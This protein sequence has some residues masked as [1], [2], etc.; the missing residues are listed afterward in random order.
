MTRSL[1]LLIAAGASLAACNSNTAPGNDREAER[2]APAQ[3]APRMNASEA[4]SGIATAA[5]QPETMT[6]ADVASVA[7]PA[8]GCVFSM[9]E[10]GFPSFLYGEGDDPGIVK[11]NGKLIILPSGG[12]GLYRDGGL[13]V[14]MRPVD[15]ELGRG[16][17]REAEMIIMLPSAEDELGFRGFSVC[18]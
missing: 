7:G 3:A 8:G 12:D 11:L 18:R 1:A 9:T 2:E 6:E 10:V 16:G 4:L 13:T 17:R 14:R 15:A 5:I